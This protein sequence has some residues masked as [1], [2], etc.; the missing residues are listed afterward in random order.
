MATERADEA[1]LD[2]STL[3]ERWSEVTNLS[4]L[5]IATLSASAHLDR[6]R[7]AKAEGGKSQRATREAM[8]GM[9]DVTDPLEREMSADLFVALKLTLKGSRGSL[10]E[11]ITTYD[12]GRV[13]VA[14]AIREML[15][16][17]VLKGYVIEN[18]G[19]ISDED[20]AETLSLRGGLTTPY[21][22]HFVDARTSGAHD[23]IRSLIGKYR[24]LEDDPDMSGVDPHIVLVI[25]RKE[26]EALDLIE[27]LY[28]GGGE[29][30]Y[31]SFDSRRMLERIN[32]VTRPKLLALIATM[33][34]R[35]VPIETLEASG[36]EDLALASDSDPVSGSRRGIIKAVSDWFASLLKD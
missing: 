25:A 35:I 23:E 7:A 30:R 33:G 36:G 29:D 18:I 16:N 5:E 15:I 27:K 34:A 19:A 3:M 6:L 21:R 20:S 1:P 14:E 9:Y 31:V 17:K 32:E 24:Q 22:S 4:P 11:K 8:L 12:L 2:A 10:R 13:T 26:L 28:G